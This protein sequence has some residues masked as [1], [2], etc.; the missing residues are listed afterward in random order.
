MTIRIPPRWWKRLTCKHDYAEVDFC[1]LWTEVGLKHGNI[2]AVGNRKMV[3]RKCKHAYLALGI[4]V[5]N[6]TGDVR[7]K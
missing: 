2:V 6:P 7:I 5:Y 1:C 4:R 3:C